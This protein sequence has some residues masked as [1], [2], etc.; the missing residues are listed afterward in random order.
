MAKIIIRMEILFS[1]IARKAM[2]EGVLRFF[3]F[4]SIDDS[5]K[6]IKI[7]TMQQRFTYVAFLSGIHVALI[8]MTKL[9]QNSTKRLDQI[10]GT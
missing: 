6:I 5:V 4:S 8:G 1:S 9:S 7:S 2:Y 10:L 3:Q